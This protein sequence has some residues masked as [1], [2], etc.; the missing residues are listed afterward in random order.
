MPPICTHRKLLFVVIFFGWFGGISSPQVKKSIMSFTF[1]FYN[2][3]IFQM[4]FVDILNEIGH[5]FAPPLAFHCWGHWVGDCS[6]TS[7]L[8]LYWINNNFLFSYRIII[9]IQSSFAWQLLLLVNTAPVLHMLVGLSGCSTPVA[10]GQTSTAPVTS[11]LSPSQRAHISSIKAT[12]A[13]HPLHK[14]I[15]YTVL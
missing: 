10:Q 7:C 6:F 3:S 5:D 14:V 4:I 15:L 1:S 11:S 9:T 13:V 8:P 12:M 2:D